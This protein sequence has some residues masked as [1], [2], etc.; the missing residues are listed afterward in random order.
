MR[1]YV[2]AP[3]VQFSTYDVYTGVC[4]GLRANGVEVVEG[5]LDH[6][7]RYH[8]GATQLMREAGMFKPD[9]YINIA[10]MAGPAIV[11]HAIAE[12]PDAVICIS[13]HN[14]H[15]SSAKTLTKV[16][17]ALGFR[18][19]MYATETPY[20]GAFEPTMAQAYD[21]IFTMERTGA[22]YFPDHPSVHYLPH[23]YNPDVHTPGDA[24]PE[25]ACDALF[26]GTW[27]NERKAL[28]SGVD[29]TGIDVQRRGYDP[30]AEQSPDAQDII[31]NPLAVRLYRSAKI[32]INH[33][34][35]TMQHGSGLHI[36]AGDA[37]SLGPRAYELAACR[38]FQISDDSREE[39]DDVLK[40]TVPT[41]RAG[42]SASLERIVRHYL[43]RPERREHLA[44]AQHQAVQ[45]QSWTE[46]ARQLLEVLTCP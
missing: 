45:G 27:F 11:Q 35:T 16:G 19:A 12:E 18:T 5:N 37:E 1:A 28:F 2:I 6:L 24:E 46:R 38:A 31:P 30:D 23:A 4:A 39:L 32:N 25:L 36:A 33:H 40:G 22:R 34:R 44:D 15:Y 9:A 20:F 13:G 26:I 3:G 8:A 14:F 41:Y 29:W 7:L 21:H 17:R 10:Q 42:D 43:K